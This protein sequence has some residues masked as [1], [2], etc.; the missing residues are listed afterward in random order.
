M[1]VRRKSI[2]FKNVLCKKV[3]TDLENWHKET[4]EVRN[5]V[6]K[7]NLYPTGPCFYKIKLLDEER[8]IFD[9][10]FYIPLCAKLRMPEGS[11]YSFH[12]EFLIEDA[13][14]Y[15]HEDISDALEVSYDFVRQCAKDNEL[16]IEDEFYN[17]LVD[18]Y[19]EQ[20]IDVCAKIKRGEDEWL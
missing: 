20:V 12:E 4:A 9:Y 13:L 18:L 6:I 1:L 7:N 2:L 3:R 10:E 16:K 11:A 14:V 19:G 15:R 17:I 5:S 8:G